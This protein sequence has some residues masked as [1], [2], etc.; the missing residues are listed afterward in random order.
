M[1]IQNTVSRDFLSTF[2]GSE[3][4]ISA[5]PVCSMSSSPAGVVSKIIL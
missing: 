5:Y 3:F 2:M 1:A 4:S